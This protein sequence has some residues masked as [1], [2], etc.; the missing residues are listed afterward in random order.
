MDW[1]RSPS[2]VAYLL[3]LLGFAE[4]MAYLMIGLT[5]GRLAEPIRRTSDIYEEQSR[6][7]RDFLE[8]ETSRTVHDAVLGWGYRPGY[9]SSGDRI[10]S[11][12]LRSE[13]EYALQPRPEVLRVAAFGDSFVYCNEVADSDAWPRIVESLDPSLEV[14]NY[15]VGGYGTDQALLRFEHE[16][17]RYNPEV[18]LIGFAPVNLRRIV[19]VYR[20]FISSRELPLV[21]P[22]F[23]LDAS[24]ALQLVPNP[25]PDPDDWRRLLEDPTAIRDWGESDQWYEPGIYDNPLYDLSALVRLSTHAWIRLRDRYLDDERLLA[26]GVFREASPA[27]HLQIAVLEQFAE[28]VRDAGARPIV[29]VLPDRDSVAARRVGDR[30]VYDPL[31]RTVGDAGIEVWDGAEAFRQAET[32]KGFSE[33]FMPGGHYSPEGNRVLA[34]WLRDALIVRHPH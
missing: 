17:D 10:N 21:K 23:R 25:L 13:R 33:W 30:R 34:A 22:R 19:N 15:G 29:L 4:G 18:V 32:G 26:D 11:A 24:G 7:I 5:Q 16:G 3:L 27:F 6:R 1:R 8:S 12:G 28:V 2:P 14:L 20:R 31:L 9:R